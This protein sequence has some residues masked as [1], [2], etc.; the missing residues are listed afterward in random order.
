MKSWTDEAGTHH[1]NCKLL[2]FAGKS[3]L[4]DSP[5]NP[6]AAIP[7]GY[8]RGGCLFVCRECGD[9]WGRILVSNSQGSKESFSEVCAV[10]CVKHKDQ[11]NIPGS[12]LSGSRNIAYLEL[13]PPAA[14]KREFEI[15]LKHLSE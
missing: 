14:L 10:A 11:W 1:E 4:G 8:R 5:Y 3:F 15:H 12:F 7:L 9:V 13:L 2:F 6:G